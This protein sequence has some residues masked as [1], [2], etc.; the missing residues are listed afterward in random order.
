MRG[1]V[2][3]RAAEGEREGEGEASPRERE[4]GGSGR[5]R[6]RRRVG[7]G[8]ATP[9]GGRQREGA[10]ERWPME[11]RQGAAGGRRLAK[12]VGERE[13]EQREGRGG[14]ARGREGREEGTASGEQRRN[15]SSASP[16]GRPARSRPS[17]R[18]CT[19][20]ALDRTLTRAS[21]PVEPTAVPP[22]VQPLSLTPLT[23]PRPCQP[24]M[25]ALSVPCSC[26][27]SRRPLLTRAHRPSP[28]T[29]SSKKQ[30]LLDARP[31]AK[32]RAFDSPSGGLRRDGS[33][34]QPQKQQARKKEVVELS[35]SSDDDHGGVR[36]RGGG[37]AADSSDDDDEVRVVQPRCAPFPLLPCLARRPRPRSLAD[38]TPQPSCYS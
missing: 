6:D 34:P 37:A 18:I 36:G 15:A 28:T 10:S 35:D 13:R 29:P 17:S 16:L 2:G 19:L 33:R 14:P 11:V 4:G 30:I 20:A 5:E 22:S 7:G 23:S 8:R 24:R 38:P 25:E 3:E 21:I 26:P 31:P 12:R 32:P 1:A 9:T 27:R